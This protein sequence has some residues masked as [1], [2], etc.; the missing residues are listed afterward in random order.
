MIC[1]SRLGGLVDAED[2][3]GS[4][5]VSGLKIAEDFGVW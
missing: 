2:F 3:G 5:E 1:T 4:K